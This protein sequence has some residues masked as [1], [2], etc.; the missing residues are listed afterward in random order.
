MEFR[1]YAW[2]ALELLGIGILWLMKAGVM[3]ALIALYVMFEM[4]RVA[5]VAVMFGRLPRNWMRY[6]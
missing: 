3:A 1:D 5:L 4:M 2:P 6:L